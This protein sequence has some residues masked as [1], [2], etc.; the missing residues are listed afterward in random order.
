MCLRKAAG[1]LCK[2]SQAVTRRNGK[3]QAL[4]KRGLWPGVRAEQARNW[5]GS[6]EQG[7]IDGG[8][9][10]TSG[11]FRVPNPPDPAQHSSPQPTWHCM[12]RC[13]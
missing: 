2:T 6:R 13:I 3:G 12:P 9:E 8:G 7:R 1:H 11:A 5:F 4:A 10:H